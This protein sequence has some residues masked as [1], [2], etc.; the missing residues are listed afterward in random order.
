MKPKAKVERRKAK[1]SPTLRERAAVAVLP[2]VVTDALVAAL[3]AKP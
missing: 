3:E 2:A 1:G